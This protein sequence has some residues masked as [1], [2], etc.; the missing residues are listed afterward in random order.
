M[1]PKQKRVLLVDDEPNTLEVLLNGLRRLGDKYVFEAVSGGT[2]ALEKLG[3]THYD[4]V[5]T[6]YLMPG[7][8]GLELMRRVSEISPETE[9]ILMTAY[10]SDMLD[11]ALEDLEVRGY[12]NKPFSLAQIR[13]TVERA[14]SNT[15]VSAPPEEN[16]ATETTTTAVG[17]HIRQLIH[18]LRVD[19]NAR[20]ALL[21][22]SNGY[23]LQISGVD[24]SLDM[25]SISALVAANF[26]AANELARLLGNGSVFKSSYHEGP[27]YDIYAHDIDGD[28]LVAVIF[29]ATSKAGMV[30]YCTGQAIDALKPLLVSDGLAPRQPRTD[31]FS[32]SV[33]RDLDSMFD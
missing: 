12:L 15:A 5:V 14:V 19:T 9:V 21:L 20:S 28:S 24:R 7:M 13:E 4:L 23:P 22:S 31:G 32:E 2:L 11:K 17:K 10:G 3:Q 1:M 26:M 25:A 33:A 30:R 8:N 18:N 6:D 27:D 16:A 29:D